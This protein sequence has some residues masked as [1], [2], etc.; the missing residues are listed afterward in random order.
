[1]SDSDDDLPMIARRR[2]VSTDAADAKPAEPTT[3]EEDTA[4][5]TNA[6]ALAPQHK[7]EIA[8]KQEEKPSVKAAAASRPAPVKQQQADDSS[9]D[10]DDVPIAARAKPAGEAGQKPMCAWLQPL[11]GSFHCAL[12]CAGAKQPGGAA[13]AAVKVRNCQGLKVILQVYCV[14]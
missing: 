10:E 1:M 11:L 12:C 6:A 2:V 5:T 4:G 14:I 3:K 9:D 8:F 7:P 13:A